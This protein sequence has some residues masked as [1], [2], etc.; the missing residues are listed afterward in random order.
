MQKLIL[1]IL[2]A[3]M[4]SPAW[5]ATYC[6]TPTG[7][8]TTGASTS[9]DW[10]N[11]SCYGNPYTVSQLNP[12]GG[13]HTVLMGAGS[14]NSYMSF[15]SSNW[16]GSAVM[17]VSAGG[18]SAGCTATTCGSYPAQQMEV[19][20]TDPAHSHVTVDCNNFT[21]KNISS[22]GITTASKRDF[23][24]G[25]GS[26]PSGFTGYNLYAT[27]NTGDASFIFS[28]ASNFLLSNSW[29]VGN[30]GSAPAVKTTG[31]SSG[32]I[33]GCHF[34]NSA[35]NPASKSTYPTYNQNGTGTVNIYNS[36]ILGNTSSAIYQ[37]SSSGTLN[38]KNS[39]I[40]TWGGIPP[41]QNSST[42]TLSYDYNLIVPPRTTSHATVSGTVVDGG[43]NI[44]NQSPR[45]RSTG[46]TAIIV[47]V[48]DQ[49]TGEF[50]YAATL[51]SIL[52]ARKLRGTM[53]VPSIYASANSALLSGYQSRGTLLLGSIGYSHSDLSLT[54]TVYSI[55]CPGTINID[56]AN[57]TITANGQALIGYK[58]KQIG[59]HSDTNVNS[60]AYWLE[61]TASC[62][63]GT[64]TSGL[65]A[66]TLGESFADSTGA[67][68][69]PYNAQLLID[70]TA[71]TGY[72]N[73]EIKQAKTVFE[74]AVSGLSLKSFAHPMGNNNASVDTALRTTGFWGGRP[75]D[76]TAQSQLS[77][78]NAY[79]I[80]GLNANQ[81]IKNASDD[82]VVSNTRSVA[83][84][85]SSVGGIIAIL[86]HDTND[87][88]AAQ[89]GLVFDT[90]ATY[91]NITI[92]DMDTA[93][94]MLRSSA[95]STT[96]NITYTRTWTDQPNYRPL[97]N[98]PAIGA[99]AAI[100]GIHDQATPATDADGR[101]VH[102]LP[103]NI[104]AY[105]GR[106]SLTVT[107]DF[108]PTGYTVRGTDSEPAIISLG[109]DSLVV[110]LSGL[111]ADE[112]IVV[113]SGSKKVK[114]FVAKGT[115]Q[116]LKGSGGSGGSSGFNW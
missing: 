34:V 49:N 59:Q 78:I 100:T 74:S 71:N 10:S 106:T 93:L 46:R 17:G 23:Q 55:T 90:L 19:V 95:W 7:T 24:V 62:T 43:H 89:W 94:G 108:S 41:I 97:P 103:P 27:D 91:P 26:S 68:A 28:G 56:R 86:A 110:D 101:I 113:K 107:S 70:A 60:I 69:S 37:D 47:P 81:Y 96:D 104:G 73:V 66:Y 3:L 109:S 14:Y 6:I 44:I 33:V 8:R 114:G 1:T 31:A 92:T 99:G 38:V 102:F 2:L 63:V 105:D 61:H 87:L 36:Y 79:R 112:A 98:S 54:G 84:Y 4:C 115:K 116:Y 53:Y 88:T 58:A 16:A 22:S 9:G 40:Q 25:A 13:P 30:N 5:G 39:T 48:T 35:N 12:S 51:E 67:Q 32:S 42:G 64:L 75:L 20:F 52:S 82:A 65:N 76:A 85:A 83:D 50:S 72:Y 18:V 11:T 77:S 57:D 21:V 29:S 80:M 111:T 15:T 45:F